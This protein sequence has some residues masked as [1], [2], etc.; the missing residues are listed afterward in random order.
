MKLKSKNMGS[1]KEFVRILF[2][3]LIIT[4]FFRSFVFMSF[5]VFGPSMCDTFN[6]FDGQCVSEDSE[7]GELVLVD[8]LVYRF[9]MPERGDI[10]VVRVGPESKMLLK[11]IV[12]LP[13]ETV[14]IKDNGFVYITTSNGDSFQL[15]ETEYLNEKNFGHTSHT[16]MSVF[17]IPENEYFVL[18]DSRAHSIDSRHCFVDDDNGDNCLFSSLTSYVPKKDIIGRVRFVMLPFAKMRFVH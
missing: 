13:G 1:T 6:I 8:R 12:G 10:V 15:D 7:R 9:F 11:R 14:E 16:R 17:E 18:G 4:F 2:L 5:K 3:F